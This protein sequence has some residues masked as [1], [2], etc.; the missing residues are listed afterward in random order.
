MVYRCTLFLTSVIVIV[1]SVSAR[2]ETSNGQAPPLDPPT[3]L[4]AKSIDAKNQLVL[5]SYHS[6]FIGFDGYSYNE[7]LEKRVSLKGVKVFTRD[8]D[9]LP[10]EKVKQ[11]LG[12]RDTPILVTSFGE[13]LPK[14]YASILAPDSLV[15]AFPEKAPV[16]K[17][18]ESPGAEVR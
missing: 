17:K 15:F 2:D 8:G 1:S 3:I 9:A 18:I 6:I 5:V 16:W 11:K 14:F 10:I 4:I 13:S 7:R 12:N